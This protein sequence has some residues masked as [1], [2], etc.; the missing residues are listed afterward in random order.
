MRTYALGGDGPVAASR[1]ADVAAY[2]AAH[3]SRDRQQAELADPATVTF[4]AECEP[5]AV[6]STPAAWP[7]TWAG[8]AQLRLHP[9]PAAPTPAPCA[10]PSPRELARLYV[11][12]AWQGRGIAHALVDAV[13]ARAVSE[14]GGADPLWLAV[15]QANARA[16]AF[17]RRRGFKIAADALFVMGDET[18]HDWL[19]TWRPSGAPSK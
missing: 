7:P 17:Y 15:Y 4:I 10:G 19:M 13:Q 3:F 1:P 12:P 9:S 11:A 2:V 8:Y 6:G 18:Q 16:V 5:A 14:P